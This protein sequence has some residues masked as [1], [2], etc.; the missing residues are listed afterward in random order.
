MEVCG[1]GAAVAVPW[2]GGGRQPAAAGVTLHE[3]RR[4]HEPGVNWSNGWTEPQG[5]GLSKHMRAF[6]LLLT[7]SSAVVHPFSLPFP[8]TRSQVSLSIG[9]QVAYIGHFLAFPSTKPSY[10]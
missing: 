8:N 7:S 2:L 10:S 5:E 6:L 1:A 4:G 3:C 9:T